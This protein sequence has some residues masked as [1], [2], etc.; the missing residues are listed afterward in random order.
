MPEAL[1]VSPP[2]HEA[3]LI[4]AAGDGDHEAFAELVSRYQDRIFQACVRLLKCRQE[5]EEACQDVFVRAFHALPRFRA[6]AKFSTWLYQIALNRCRDSWKRSSQKLRQRSHSLNESHEFIPERPTHATAWNEEVQ[7]L[8]RG[9]ESLSDKHREVLILIALEDLGHAECARI[10]K[11]SERA[12]EGR[13]RRARKALARWWQK[14][15]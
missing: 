1:S 3:M 14:A 2:D 9:L 15:E 13:L 6:R 8:A 4:K 5:A 11:C 10:L 7:K 12:V